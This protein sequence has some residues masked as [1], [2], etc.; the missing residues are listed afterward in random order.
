MWPTHAILDLYR[1]DVIGVQA[2]GK[3]LDAYDNPVHD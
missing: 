3:V 2:I 1:K